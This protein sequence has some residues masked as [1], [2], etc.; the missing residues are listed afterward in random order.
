MQSVVSSHCCW[1]NDCEQE[2]GPRQGREILPEF[3]QVCPSGMTTTSYSISMVEASVV[4]VGS[5]VVGLNVV[6]LSVEGLAVVGLAVDVGLIVEGL[7]VMAAEVGL[8]VAPEPDVHQAPL[9]AW[10]FD[11]LSAHQSVSW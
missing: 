7:S 5:E 9:Q 2:F 10:Q 4:E 11:S 8:G 1:Q 3:L 6:G